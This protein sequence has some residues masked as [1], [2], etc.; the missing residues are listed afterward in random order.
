MERAL[1]IS[2]L[3]EEQRRR[4]LG[5]AGGTLRT[6]VV[7]LMRAGTS[8]MQCKDYEL[9]CTK[10]SA[11]IEIQP[12]ETLWAHRSAALRGLGRFQ[13]A[14]SDAQLA[15]EVA[16]TSLLGYVRKAEALQANNRPEQAID[17]LAAAVAA[18]ADA[19][20]SPSM[21]KEASAALLKDFQTLRQAL[22]ESISATTVPLT[23]AAT[24]LDSLDLQATAGGSSGSGGEGGRGSSAVELIVSV[25]DGSLTLSTLYEAVATALSLTPLQVLDVYTP[26]GT[27]IDS[28]ESCSAF[29]ASVTAAS[30][31]EPGTATDP[32]AIDVEVIEDDIVPD[33][34]IDPILSMV[35]VDPVVAGD[36][37]SYERSSILRW[38]KDHDESPQTVRTQMIRQLLAFSRPF[39]TDC[40]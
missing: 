32:A 34:F 10:F 22:E 3:G 28:N 36:G 4:A 20:V 13:E 16:P 31:A 1:L 18:G 38:L 35:F 21:P 14:R 5:S 12:T 24:K 40:L 37:M 19:A 8:A 26:D 9:A 6:G 33:N 15:I 7:E 39:L 11:A 25:R 27:L 30:A 17:A 2:M 29:A 23:L